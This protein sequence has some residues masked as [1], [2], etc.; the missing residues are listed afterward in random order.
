MVHYK[1][2]FFSFILLMACN[3]PVAPADSEQEH[4]LMVGPRKTIRLVVLGTLQDAGSPQIG[5]QKE[6]CA[7]LFEYPDPK[8]MVVSL[9]LIDDTFRKTYLFEATPDMPKQVEMLNRQSGSDLS[10]VPDAVFLTHA[11][12]GH[13]TGLM[14]LGKEAMNANKVKT[15]A[16]PRMSNFLTTNGPWSQLVASENIVLDV[17]DTNRIIPLGPDITVKPILVPHRDEFSE[18]VGYIIK[19]PN[20]KVLFI[21]DIDKWE[22]WETDIVE[23]VKSVDYAFL[24]ATFYDGAEINNRDISEIPHPFVVESMKTFGSLAHEE[25]QKIYLIHFNHTNPL[26]GDDELQTGVIQEFGFNIAKTEMVLEL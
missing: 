6:C 14:Y 17:L 3:N 2:V 11:H 9:G 22:K 21:P 7:D 4:E 13:Y 18:T 15:Y 10:K 24:D 8:R 5:C 12:I 23:L 19:G 16:M 1:F 20:K 26:L 25:R